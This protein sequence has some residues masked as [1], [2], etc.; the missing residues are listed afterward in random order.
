MPTCG[1]IEVTPSFDANNVS[2]S[3]CT[4]GAE[5][6]RGQQVSITATVQNTN[7]TAANA[8]V[9]LIVDGTQEATTTVTVG[10][11]R[12]TTANFRLATNSLSLGVHSVDAEVTDAQQA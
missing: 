7:D 12:S 4:G 9:G 1:T 2:V 3:T 6:T 11:N 8:T 5:V 10:A